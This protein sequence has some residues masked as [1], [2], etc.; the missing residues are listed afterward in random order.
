MDRPC[1]SMAGLALAGGILALSMAPTVTIAGPPDGVA[2]VLG[3]TIHPVADSLVV[4]H[5]LSP[6]DLIFRRLAAPGLYDVWFYLF[7]RRPLVGGWTVDLAFDFDRRPGHG[8]DIEAWEPLTPRSSPHAGF[9]DAG[10]DHGIRLEWNRPDC[11]DANHSDLLAGNDGWFRQSALRLR[12]R[13]HDPDVLA[14]VDPEPGVPATLVQCFDDAFRLDGEDGWTRYDG[15]VFSAGESV[16]EARPIPEL[17]T[18]TRATTWGE[19]KAR[20]DSHG[21]RP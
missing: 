14:L 19:L 8:I 18:P 5:P 15:P 12:V 1:L 3:A 21:S 20:I 10:P 16:T 6:D 13:V 17:K 2:L 9:P 7:T 11:F 4:P